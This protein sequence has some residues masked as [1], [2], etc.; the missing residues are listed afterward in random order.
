MDGKLRARNPSL[1]LFQPLGCHQPSTGG[2]VGWLPYLC[3]AHHWTISSQVFQ[4]NGS[5]TACWGLQD[6]WLLGNLVSLAILTRGCP[7]PS[8]VLALPEGWELRIAGFHRLSPLRVRRPFPQRAGMQTLQLLHEKVFSLFG[9]VWFG[10]IP[11][12]SENS[13]L[14][15][16]ISFLTRKPIHP[17]QLWFQVM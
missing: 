7:G 1:Q 8:A 9:M 13:K 15:S 11:L 4:T 6:L 2:L 17:G 14:K 5:S 3:A 12:Q 10:F 16:R